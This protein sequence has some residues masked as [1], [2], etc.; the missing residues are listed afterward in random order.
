MQLDTIWKIISCTLFC[1]KYILS[2]ENMLQNDK[3]KWKKLN[4]TTTQLSLFTH[5]GSKL[6]TLVSNDVFKPTVQ[7]MSQFRVQRGGT[8]A[9]NVDMNN[10]RKQ[11]ERKRRKSMCKRWWTRRKRTR[12]GECCQGWIQLTRDNFDC[13]VVLTTT[14]FFFFSTAYT[15]NPY[16]SHNF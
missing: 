10:G 3:H 6:F 14:V 13:D 15:Q 8:G 1:S 2:H 9:L 4:T 5:N 12:G 7:N 11:S 16:L